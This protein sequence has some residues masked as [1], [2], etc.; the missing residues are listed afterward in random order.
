MV[1]DSSLANPTLDATTGR[2]SST[3]PPA[4]NWSAGLGAL[5]SQV[6]NGNGSYVAHLDS[7]VLGDPYVSATKHAYW[8]TA[9]STAPRPSLDSARSAA[10][11][12]NGVRLRGLQR[13]AHQ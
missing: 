5:V 10:G 12:R 2:F 7:V 13:A 11:V 8:F 1:L 9:Q 3:L 4:D 6:L